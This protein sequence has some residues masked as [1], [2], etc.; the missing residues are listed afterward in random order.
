M[1]PRFRLLLSNFR[2]WIRSDPAS[3]EA[4]FLIRI[5]MKSRRMKAAGL[6]A[7]TL[8][9]SNTSYTSSAFGTSLVERYF[10]ISKAFLGFASDRYL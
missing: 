2:S 3:E 10:S 7:Q 9:A 5:Y 4:S 8:P 1:Q 6:C